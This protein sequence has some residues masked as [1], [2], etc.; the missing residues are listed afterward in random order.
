MIDDLVE[1]TRESSL[2]L[3]PHFLEKMFQSVLEPHAGV[4]QAAVY[5]L[6][7]CAQHGGAVFAQLAQR[8]A[9]QPPQTSSF[10]EF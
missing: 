1:H 4:R 10:R 8:A 3:F 2:S 5:G 6:G 7:V 9:N